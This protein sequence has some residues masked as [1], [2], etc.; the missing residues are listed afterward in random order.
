MRA[1]VSLIAL[2]SLP[3][4]VV[5]ACG[6]QPAPL[7][8]PTAVPPATPT[9][10]TA[11]TLIPPDADTPAAGICA[12]AESE[13]VTFTVSLEGPPDPR[14]WQVRPSQRL[15]IANPTPD[16]V[17][18]TFAGQDHSVEPGTTVRVDQAFGS[19][20]APG[21]HFMYVTQGAGNLPEFWLL[22][23]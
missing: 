17:V 23:E 10:T 13:W 18:V 4:W 1:R 20:L 9:I 22:P 2:F 5:A 12:E 6:P 21:V 8:T 3:A 16:R 14:C 11:P 15:E 19:Y 7:A